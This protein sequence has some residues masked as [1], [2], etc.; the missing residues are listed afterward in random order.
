MAKYIVTGAAGFIANKVAEMLLDRGDTVIGIDNL[1]DAYDVRMKDYRLDQLKKREG[2]SF[3]KLDIADREDQP[4][5]PGGGTC[6]G[7]R[8]MGVCRYEYDRHPQPAGTVPQG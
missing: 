1:N 8:S 5:G 4:G 6:L 3:H 2:F 7:G